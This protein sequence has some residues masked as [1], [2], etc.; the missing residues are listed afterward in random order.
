MR[1]WVQVFLLRCNKQICKQNYGNDLHYL[2]VNGMSELSSDILLMLML[3]DQDWI[4][5]MALSDWVGIF[6]MRI[7]ED[8][9]WY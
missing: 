1:Q 5:L 8:P 7:G 4:F 9:D 3:T 6:H 2:S